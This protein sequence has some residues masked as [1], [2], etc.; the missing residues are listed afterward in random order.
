MN[1]ELHLETRLIIA[2]SLI[3]LMVI[4]V[5]IGIRAVIYRRNSARLASSGRRS[6]IQRR[7][8]ML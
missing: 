5:S 3:T 2:Y 6:I 7:E 8:E 4:A 1:K